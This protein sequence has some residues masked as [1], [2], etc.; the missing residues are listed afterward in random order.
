M[1]SIKIPKGYSRMSPIINDLLDILKQYSK[2]TFGAEA[3]PLSVAEAA[4]LVNHI[5]EGNIKP[6]KLSA[7]EIEELDNCDDDLQ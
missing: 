7:E 3:Y 1:K 2:I 5:S 4:L 6:H